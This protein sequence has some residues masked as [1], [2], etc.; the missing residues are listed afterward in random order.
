MRESL[1]QQYRQNFSIRKNKYNNRKR[2]VESSGWLIIL[3]GFL[4]EDIFF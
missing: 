4:I 1:K 3:T 2:I